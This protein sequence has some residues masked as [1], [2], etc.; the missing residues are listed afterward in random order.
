MNPGAPL[1]IQFQLRPKPRPVQDA[2]RVELPSAGRLPQVTRVLA[3]AI[4]FDEMIR[5][6]DARDYADV[7]RQTCLCRERVSQI[8]RLNYLAPDIQMELLYL[9]PVPTGRYPISETAMR[10][11]ANLLSRA[12]QRREWARLK[13]L[14]Q[15][16]FPEATVF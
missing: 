9:P 11:I 13:G 5:K 10:R 12:D 15:L 7:A 16:D 14:R 8:M 2:V 3:L 1:E 4:H 6:G